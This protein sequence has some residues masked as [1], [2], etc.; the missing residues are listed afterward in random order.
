MSKPLVALLAMIAAGFA[1]I[2]MAMYFD[3]ASV[4]VFYRLGSGYDFDQKSTGIA[5]LMPA[6]GRK[7]SAIL[8][9]TTSDGDKHDDVEMRDGSTKHLDYD[10]RSVLRY[11]EAFYKGPSRSEPGPLQYVKEHD[12][13]GH[14]VSEMH[15][16]LDGST[17][18]DGRLNGDVYVRRFFFGAPATGQNSSAAAP[19]VSLKQTFDIAWKKLTET[20]YR[21]DS[22]VAALHSWQDK[23][24]D[25]E[26]ISQF[27]ADG[28]T[29]TLLEKRGTYSDDRTF[30]DLDK[31]HYASVNVV[32]NLGGT[33]YV[34]FD[35]ANRPTLKLN[36]S[37]LRT[38]TVFLMDAEG[39]VL[40]KQTWVD[41]WTKKQVNGEWP[42]WLVSVDHMRKD[43]VVDEHFAFDH[44]KRINAAIV[45]NPESDTLYGARR[46]Y[47]V[48]PSGLAVSV[49]TY[50]ERN[51]ADVD[52]GKPLTAA[53][54]VRFSLPAFVIERPAIMDGNP[55]L[56]AVQ[57]GFKLYGEP[58]QMEH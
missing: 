35:K 41:D 6:L 3:F 9:R 46:E 45:H 34:F 27:A 14:L 36:F 38:D 42:R 55:G 23:D 16:R 8:R 20:E 4:P 33:T 50:T 48:E 25:I 47:V 56:P 31:G 17:E 43:G 5:V 21:P 12:E 2:G 10:S 32:S 19:V 58:P 39:R 18:M 49:T 52:R 15:Y 37:N 40:W 13:A 51:N 54:N 30:Y 11:V 28:N 44:D 53:D 24:P 22:S 57:K 26:T 29:L 1:A 7:E